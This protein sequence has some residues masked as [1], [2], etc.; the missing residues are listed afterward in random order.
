MQVRGGAYAELFGDGP[1]TS[2][3]LHELLCSLQTEMKQN[4]SLVTPEAL[5]A[6][7]ARGVSGGCARVVASVACAMGASAAIGV[8]RGCLNLALGANK[9]KPSDA[10]RIGAVCVLGSTFLL[11]GPEA[12]AMLE[13]R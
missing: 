2:S 13:V 10:A 5:L 7:V 12:G 1:V 9:P 8:M 6:V 4:K 3:R 11:L